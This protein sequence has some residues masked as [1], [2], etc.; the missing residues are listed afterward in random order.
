MWKTLFFFKS[1]L[2]GDPLF[3]IAYEPKSRQN[4]LQKLQDKYIIK[5]YFSHPNTA[6]GIKAVWLA[7]KDLAAASRAYQ[8]IGLPLGKQLTNPLLGAR[9][10]EVLAGSGSIFLLQPT[11]TEGHMASFLARRGQ[12]IIGLSI[13]VRNLFLAQNL[14]EARTK[15]HFARAGCFFSRASLFLQS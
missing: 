11:T 8:A 9:G 12:G 13:A 6:Q 14:I 10:Q 4:L 15:R 7:V 1:P 3:F 5:H 2:P